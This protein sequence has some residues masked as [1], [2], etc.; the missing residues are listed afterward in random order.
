MGARRRGVII[1]VGLVGLAASPI[2]APARQ[3]VRVRIERFRRRSP[4]PVGAFLEAP[5]YAEPS[6][7]P[8][9][10]DDTTE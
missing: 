7:R 4:D 5:C 6:E 1:G 9:P 3:A 10:V 8:R 2:A